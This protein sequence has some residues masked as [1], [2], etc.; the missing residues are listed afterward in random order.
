MDA[1]RRKNWRRRS[2]PWPGCKGYGKNES[3]HPVG[4]TLCGRPPGAAT[5][6]GWRQHHRL[7]ARNCVV[8][9]LGQPHRA[10]GGSIIGCQHVTV[11]SPAWGSHTGLPLPNLGLFISFRVPQ[12]PRAK[13]SNTSPANPLAEPSQN[14]PGPKVQAV[15]LPNERGWHTKISAPSPPA[16]V[17]LN[18]P[19]VVK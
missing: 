16:P 7:P 17:T 12:R 4:A 9:R 13:P 2:W 6:G 18:G 5:Q 14:R 3:P 8:A 15:M 11:W 19:C 10:V 1:E